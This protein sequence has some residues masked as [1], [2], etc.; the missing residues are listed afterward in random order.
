M[1]LLQRFG[2]WWRGGTGDGSREGGL[3]LKK[4]PRAACPKQNY[5]EPHAVVTRGQQ[6]TCMRCGLPMVRLNQ[7]ERWETHGAHD[8]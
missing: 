4:Y 3:D 2:R 8:N 7:P 1:S 5:Q 6:S